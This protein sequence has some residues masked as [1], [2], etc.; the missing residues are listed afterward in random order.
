M[1]EEL[2]R[3][4]REDFERFYGNNNQHIIRLNEHN[5]YINP[6]VQDAWCG[7]MA[8]YT[9]FHSV[10]KD[11]VAIRYN[12]LNPKAWVIYHKDNLNKKDFCPNSFLNIKIED[13]AEIRPHVFLFIGDIDNDSDKLK[14]L[15]FHVIR[16]S[17]YYQ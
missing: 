6:F 5:E 8:C 2:K 7:W 14:E 1:D 10:G 3:K 13:F 9:Y 15:G 16:D 17:F 12:K 4:A 11:Y